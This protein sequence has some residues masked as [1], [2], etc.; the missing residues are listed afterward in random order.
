MG[1]DRGRLDETVEYLT[2][3][4]CENAAYIAKHAEFIL[5]CN[6]QMPCSDSKGID[7]HFSC[8]GEGELL[9]APLSNL[10]RVGTPWVE[11]YKETGKNVVV[12]SIKVSSNQK[13]LRIEDI[14]GNR[15]KT[16]L[17]FAEGVANEIHFDLQLVSRDPFDKS[18]F[19]E[20]LKVTLDKEPEWFNDAINFKTALGNVLDHELK[21][22]AIDDFVKLELQRRDKV[23]IPAYIRAGVVV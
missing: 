18:K 16:M 10:E 9:F 8:P 2:I 17:A 6:C 21:Y 19:K 1:A 12:V 20:Q 22:G 14:L 3:S 11:A 23:G 7:R 4:D 13:S 5:V 15:K